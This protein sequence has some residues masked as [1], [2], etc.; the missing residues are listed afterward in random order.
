MWKGLLAAAVVL[1]CL[2]V[3][4][5][6]YII[7][8]IRVRNSPTAEGNRVR[9]ETPFGSV[10][11]DARDDMRADPGTVPIYPGAEREKKKS[12]GATINFDWGSGDK[13][14][15]IAASEYSTPDSVAQVREWYRGKLPDWTVSDKDIVHIEGSLK[16]IVSIKARDGRT[17]IGI[18]TI[19]QPEAN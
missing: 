9:V 7:P 12:G 13:Q 14:F 5:V 6:S 15:S 18:A 4:A 10:R 11:V 8:N 3:I 2:A 16:R 17:R 19:G 1:V